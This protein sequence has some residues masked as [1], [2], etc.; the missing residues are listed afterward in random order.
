[1]DD[2]RFENLREV[3]NSVNRQNLCKP[4]KSNKVGLLGVS[5]TLS[6]RRFVA[7]INIDGEHVYLGTYSTPTEAHAAYVDA[8]RKHHAGCMI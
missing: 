4:H 5:P 8:K 6:R 7:Q 3:T 1:M 2:N